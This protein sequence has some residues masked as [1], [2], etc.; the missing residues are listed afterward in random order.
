MVQ[1]PLCSG[2]EK[3]P[4]DEEGRVSTE[5]TQQAGNRG[6]RAVRG[7]GSE[8][9]P[10]PASKPREACPPVPPHRLKPGATDQVHQACGGKSTRD[11]VSGTLGPALTLETGLGDQR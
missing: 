5:A 10:P 8:A 3:D 9:S 11:G 4:P 6:F 7:R 1:R 2:A